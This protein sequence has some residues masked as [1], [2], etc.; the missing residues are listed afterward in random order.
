MH[1]NKIDVI[2]LIRYCKKEKMFDIVCIYLYCALKRT[3][4]LGIRLKYLQFLE[5]RN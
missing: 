4:V 5:D 1:I 3:K 2:I